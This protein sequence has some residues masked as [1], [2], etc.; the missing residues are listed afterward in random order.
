MQ[1]YAYVLGHAE[2]NTRCEKR[3]GSTSI[4]GM[5]PKNEVARE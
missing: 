2:G 1:L 4:L 3:S 5:T